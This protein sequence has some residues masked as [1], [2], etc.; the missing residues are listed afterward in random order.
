MIKGEINS[1]HAS[2]NLLSDPVA[3]ARGSDTANLGKLS[4]FKGFRY[5][6]SGIQFWLAGNRGRARAFS[7]RAGGGNRNCAST[8]RG[9]TS[10]WPTCLNSA[11]T[12]KAASAASL[13]AKPIGRDAST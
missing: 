9:L 2:V 4:L 11:K 1:W 5:E 12:R 7:R 8:A 10:I 6:S 3:T 13:T